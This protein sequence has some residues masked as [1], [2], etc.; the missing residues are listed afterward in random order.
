[1]T[2]MRAPAAAAH[3]ALDGLA[4]RIEFMLLT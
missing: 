2:L 1:V 4:G 3:A